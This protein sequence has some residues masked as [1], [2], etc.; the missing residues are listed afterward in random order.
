M[1]LFRYAMLAVTVVIVVGCKNET[2]ILNELKGKIVISTQNEVSELDVKSLSAG[3]PQW[4]VVLESK[5][6]YRSPSLSPDGKQIVMGYLSAEERMASTIESSPYYYLVIYNSNGTGKTVLLKNKFNYEY[7][8]WSPDGKLIAYIMYP[9]WPENRIGKLCIYDLK[10]KRIKYVDNISAAVD[11]VAWSPDSQK[12]AFTTSDFGVALYDRMHDT[13]KVLAL[14]GHS[15]VFHPNGQDVYYIQKGNQ[16]LCS[17]RM[18]GS[19]NRIVQKAFFDQLVKFS[20]DGQYLLFVGGGFHFM[21]IAGSEY[22]TLEFIDINRLKTFK[23]R[24]FVTSY[25]ASWIE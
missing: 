6:E 19:S 11:R 16:A 21:I 24:E 13:A 3:N 12:V 8:S 2:L 25:G 17:I 14:S 18:D 5:D 23:I 9:N 4:R 10:N 15:P 22:A 20:R 1:N 7:P